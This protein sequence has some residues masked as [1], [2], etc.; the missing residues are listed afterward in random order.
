MLFLA[1]LAAGTASAQRPNTNYDEAKAGTYTLPDPLILRNG[2]RV[3]SAA[4]W[5]RLRRPEILEMF[6]ANVYG[7]S[8]IGRA[9]V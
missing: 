4:D 2:K 1:V 8:Q 5:S 3:S 9:H 6:R 7:R